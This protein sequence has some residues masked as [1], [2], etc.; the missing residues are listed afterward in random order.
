M[1]AIQSLEELRRYVQTT[2]CERHALDSKQFPL[3]ESVLTRSGRPCGLYFCQPGPR[4]LKAHAV[5][6]SEHAVLAFYDSSG[7]RFHKVRLSPGPDPQRL[8]A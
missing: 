8:A 3:V 2:L 5:W 7:N 4:L 6:D 1:Q